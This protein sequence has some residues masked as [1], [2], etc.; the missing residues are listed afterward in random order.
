MEKKLSY[1]GKH[2]SLLVASKKVD[3][4]VNI[5]HVSRKKCRKTHK[6]NQ[7]F[8]INK[9]LQNVGTIR[10]IKDMKNRLSSGNACYCSVRIF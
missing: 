4:E 8:E 3:I 5:V 7:S 1:Q 9:I 10:E 2:E 6:S